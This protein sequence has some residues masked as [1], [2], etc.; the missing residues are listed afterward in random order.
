M[1][2]CRPYST[3]FGRRAVK[4]LHLW[5]KDYDKLSVDAVTC[6]RAAF[7]IVAFVLGQTIRDGKLVLDPKFTKYLRDHGVFVPSETAR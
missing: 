6:F 3:G 2:R 5:S 7:T 4:Y 1:A